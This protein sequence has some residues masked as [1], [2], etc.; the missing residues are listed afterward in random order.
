MFVTQKL[1]ASSVQFLSA[2]K[3][4]EGDREE[5]NE[6][7]AYLKEEEVEVHVYLEG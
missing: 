2:I 6:Y 3:Q 1:R 5:L 7:L 4:R